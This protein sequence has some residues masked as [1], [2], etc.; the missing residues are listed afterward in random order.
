MPTLKYT[1]PPTVRGFIRDYV[2]G[3][4]FYDWITGPVGS[5]KTT[6][7][8]MKLVYMAKLQ[9][10]SE[11]GIRHSRAVVVR[12]TAPQLRDTTLVSW[13]YWF[14]DGQAG[15]WKATDKNFILRFDDVECEV[16]FRPL[17]TPDDIARVL[18]LEITFA[19]LDEFVQI[20]RE[21]IEALSARCGRWKPPS[22]A[23]P[24]NWGMWGASNTGT[25]DSWWFDFLHDKTKVTTWTPEMLGMQPER[26]SAMVA[27]G[28]VYDTN[29]KYFVQPSALGPRAENVENLPGGLGYYTNQV[30]GKSEAWVKQFVESEWGFSISGT[31]VISSFK[32][33]LHV[34]TKPLV[35]NP[36]RKLIVGLDPG[37]GGT[38]AIFM[39]EDT[40]G[41]LL[42]L[43]ELITT[44]I[45]MTRFLSDHFKPYVRDRFGP[46]AQVLICPDP[47]AAI[48]SNSDANTVV[49]VIR[50]MYDTWMESNNRLPLR[51][52]AIDHY[53]TRLIEGLPALQIDPHHAPVLIRALKGGWRWVNDPKRDQTRGA[54]P[55][56]NPW[57]HPGDGFGYGC[58]YFHRRTER[59]LR[60]EPASGKSFTPPR[61]FGASYHFQ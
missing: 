45:P 48:R 36:L 15:Q 26:W 51:L 23:P 54:E 6:G 39:Q 11:D 1:P 10:K 14:K 2:P 34:A 52:N 60:S 18:S 29:A 12:N 41:R 35:Y 57:S 17:D 58:R 19:I 55:E 5:G 31:P 40:W 44:N 38:A 49:A 9:E 8:F 13:G 20:P 43:G 37:L 24:T 46:D 56:K 30:K 47:A 42:V 27:M 28:L 59:E 53:T 4:L 32:A 3:A 7:I 50:K 21:V 22:Y 33:A 61:S 25:E 16:M